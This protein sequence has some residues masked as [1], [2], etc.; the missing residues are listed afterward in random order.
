MDSK[1]SK[2]VVLCAFITRTLWGKSLSG[3]RFIL[4]YFEILSMD[5][6]EA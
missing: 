4:I 6:G 2:V 3:A 5:R 1:S